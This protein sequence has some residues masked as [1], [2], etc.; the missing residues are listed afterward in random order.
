MRILWK[1]LKIVKKL[2]KKNQDN[3]YGDVNSICHNCETQKYIKYGFKEKI[4]YDE[5]IK[6]FK[7]RLQCYKC[8]VFYRLSINLNYGLT[9]TDKIKGNRAINSLEHVAL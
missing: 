5:E 2:L 6:Q 8:E 3:R 1:H 9:Y 7:I 4:V